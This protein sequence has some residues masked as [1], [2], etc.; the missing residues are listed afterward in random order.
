MQT[1]TQIQCECGQFKAELTAFPKNSPGR[2][3]C[4]CDDC[5]AYLSYIDRMDLLG[6]SGLS[7]IIPVYPAEIKFIAGKENLKCVRLSNKGMHRWYTSCCRT[8][9]A[10]TRPKLP[11]IGILSR[12]YNLKDPSL[13]EKSFGPV[14]SSIMGRFAR[15]PVIAGTANNMNLKAFKF[16]L[17]FVLKGLILGRGKNSPFFLADG[18]TPIAPETTLTKEQRDEIQKKL[19]F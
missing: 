15:G 1:F 4:Y 8:P 2:L 11:W 3:A 18:K 16:V 6:A 5:Q 17:P 10:N 13:L 14:G 19:G 7:E 12:V 9:I